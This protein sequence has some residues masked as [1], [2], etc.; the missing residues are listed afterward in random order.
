MYVSTSENW[1]STAEALLT[2][3]NP[4]V[5][6]HQQ[7]ALHDVMTGLADGDR[8]KLIMA[9]G[10]GKTFTALKIAE[11]YS[12]TA[13]QNSNGRIL[14][15][16]PS[17]ALL[18]QSLLEW[19]AQSETPLHCYA[20]C[21]DT[22][23]GKSADTDDIR[24][25]DLPFPATTDARKLAAQMQSLAGQKPLTV[26]FSTY[27]SLAAIHDAQAKHGAPAFDL[28]VC[29]EAHRT[30]GVTLA[31]GDESHFVK[32]HDGDYIKASKRLYM[33]ATPRIYMDSVKSSAKE[34]KAELCS[35]D[36]VALYGKELHRLG[37]GEAI[38]LELLTD[39]KV[40]V[41]A[42]DEKFVAKQ[43]QRELAVAAKA[44]SNKDFSDYLSDLV[45]ITGCWNGLSKR[46]ASAADITDMASDA[47]PMRRAVAFAKSIK[48]S[49]QVKELFASIVEK[50][51]QQATDDGEEAAPD[52]L[53]CEVDHVDGTM[54]ALQRNNKLDWLK[55]DTGSEGS[56]CRILSNARCLS[57]GVDVPSLDAVMFLNPRNSVVDVVQTVG[58]V[59]RKVDGKKYGYIILPIGIPADT[60]PEVALKDNDKYKVVW[61]SAAS[62]AL[63]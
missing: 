52:F 20:V 25:H 26:V 57:E 63:A 11:R 24:L 18:S 22:A 48:A 3:Q 37:F 43:F 58:R 62:P 6:P 2:D 15:L 33:T 56:V 61:Q 55:A 38:N 41:L 5:T 12:S 9:C 28:V 30:T 44:K 13:P 29:D 17:I 31:D 14:F 59:M 36:D 40:M 27:Q 7:A 60:L 47:A 1:T 45:K 35:M 53:R 34:A 23:V 39:Y 4:P 42:V 54:N 49:E 10:T 46:M 32:I 16:V 8:G 50:Y 19:A 51:A 21:S